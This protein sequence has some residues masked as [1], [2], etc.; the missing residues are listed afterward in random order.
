MKLRA[1]FSMLLTVTAACVAHAE[2]VTATRAWMNCQGGEGVWGEM[3][4]SGCNEV[5]KSGK[6]EGEKL[7]LVHYFRGN[8][9]LQKAEYRKAIDD[10]SAALKLK[11]DDANALH[12]RCWARAVLNK[13][14]EDAL[15]DC[16]ES[17][18]LRPSDA[19]TLGGRG[20]LYMR[21]GFFRTAL[22]DYDAALELEPNNALNLFGRGKAKIATGDEA[23]G[24]ADLDAARAINAKIG[25]V[26][27][28]Y[29][30]GESGGIW[31]AMLD[32]W[33]AAMQW[34]Y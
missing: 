21:L 29:E 7:A 33:R 25:D 4:V 34:L 17:L 28:R 10:Y 9:W 3:R 20:F 6:V 2:D 11:A 23:G 8:A 19:E 30:A 32:Y 12:E 16:N 27:A 15:S 5:I 1:A 22:L 24:K 31:A 14:L 18:R 26:F 13:D